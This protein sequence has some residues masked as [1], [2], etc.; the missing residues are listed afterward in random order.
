M[1]AAACE[2]HGELREGPTGWEWE[3]P[4]KASCRS[5]T[6]GWG[7]KTV[8]GEARTGRKPRAASQLPVNAG[9]NLP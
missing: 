2:S 1:V 3:G 5:K 6:A 9:E 4:V 7:G 8:D